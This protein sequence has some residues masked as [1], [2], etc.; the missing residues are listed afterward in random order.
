MYLLFNG[1]FMKYIIQLALSSIAVMIGA[2][3]LPGV[4]VTTVTGAV[5]AA[6]LIGVINTIFRPLLILLTLPINFLT[7]GLFT[8]VL[9]GILIGIVDALL[10]Q[11]TIQSFAL[12]VLFS[13]VLTLINFLMY[14]FY[15]A[16]KKSE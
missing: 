10:P 12:A 13:V 2:Y 8:F 14:P 4:E 16:A 1:N 7:L 15:K 9:N 3:I 11:L 6:L 5:I